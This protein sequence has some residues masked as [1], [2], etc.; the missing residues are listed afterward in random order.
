[1]LLVATCSVNTSSTYAAKDKWTS[2]ARLRRVS[3]TGSGTFLICSGLP[4]PCIVACTMHAV[5]L[6]TCAQMSMRR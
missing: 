6:R 3:R 5:E 2:S 4:T 1:M